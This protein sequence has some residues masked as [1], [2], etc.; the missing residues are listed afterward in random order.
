[1]SYLYEIIKST[2][3]MGDKPEFA[4]R[5]DSTQK[6]YSALLSTARRKLEMI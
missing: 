3:R 5:T 6:K 1:M 4:E 2:E